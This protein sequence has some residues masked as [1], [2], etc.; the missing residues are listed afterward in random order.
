MTTH[1][2]KVPISASLLVIGGLLSFS[3][4]LSLVHARPGGPPKK[5]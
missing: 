1:F 5:H 3:I 4:F 2:W